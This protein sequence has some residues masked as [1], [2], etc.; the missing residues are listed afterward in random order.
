M[1][2]FAS[3]VLGPELFWVLIYLVFRWLAA[4][5]VPPTEAGNAALNWAIWLAAIVGVAASFAFIAM[6]GANRWVMFARL[7]VVGFIGLNA[8]VI[9]ACEWIK[10]PVP[11]QN[12]GLMALWIVAVIAGGA[13][14]VL[15][16]IA[17]AI[18]VRMSA[19]AVP[20]SLP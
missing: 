7:T 10:Y 1:S 3:V 11:G 8:C 20:P 13:V 19:A 5:N 18:I 17:T 9:L 15:G 14:W 4:R 6:P 16:A 2:R 12:S